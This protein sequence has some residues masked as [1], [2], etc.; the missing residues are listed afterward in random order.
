MDIRDNFLQKVEELRFS[1]NIGEGRGGDNDRRRVVILVSDLL[2]QYP[3]DDILRLLSTSG[4]SIGVG[5]LGPDAALL[6]LGFF[7]GALYSALSK[8]QFH[9]DCVPAE[10]A[11]REACRRRRGGDF[12][13]L[14]IHSLKEFTPEEAVRRFPIIQ[15]IIAAV[16][17]EVEVTVSTKEE[18]DG[19]RSVRGDELDRRFER[20][21]VFETARRGK[22]VVRPNAP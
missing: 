5:V 14:V 2:C 1:Y 3:T 13:P 4:R 7:E 17:G 10:A 16:L 11:Y 21:R 18:T 15:S 6:A 8:Y 12:N 22:I 19:D 9:C 20:D